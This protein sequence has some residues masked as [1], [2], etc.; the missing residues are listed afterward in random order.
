MKQ[1]IQTTVAALALAARAV[2]VGPLSES[3]FVDTE[4]STNVAISVDFALMTRM[5]LS[6]SLEASPTNC[7]EA[8]VGHDADADGVLSV[9]EAVYTLGF[10]CGRWFVRDSAADDERVEPP[11]DATSR[12]KR[13]FILARRM[14]DPA[15]N[16]VRVT[17]RGD[18]VIGE[19]VIAEGR[20]PGF[21][22]EVR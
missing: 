2:E 13:M 3:A 14:L 4:I 11:S 21:M 10:D 16:L 15:W 19:C 18:G 8:S 20:L 7:V 9:D 17:R 6:L 22:L 12:V 5:V 1:I